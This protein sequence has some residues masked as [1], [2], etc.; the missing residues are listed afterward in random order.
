MEAPVVVKPKVAAVKKALSPKQPEKKCDCVWHKKPDG[1]SPKKHLDYLRRNKLKPSPCMPG[2]EKEKKDSPK[3][4]AISVEK[5][6]PIH[7]FHNAMVKLWHPRS[8]QTNRFWGNLVMVVREGKTPEWLITEHQLVPE[9]YFI[10]HNKKEINLMRVLKQGET[11]DVLRADSG[12]VKHLK[13]FECFYTKPIDKL[14]LSGYGAKKALLIGPAKTS[15]AMRYVGY[16]PPTA[17]PVDA[18]TDTSRKGNTLYH[19]ASTQNNSC[20]GILVDGSRIVGLHYGTSG[21]D[22]KKGMNNKAVVLQYQLNAK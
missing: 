1:I 2:F 12:W 19:S 13:G 9:A 21:A 18:V 16:D 6:L 7:H 22:N 10:D 4:E 17:E 14:I 3:K 5:P 11:L 8:V 20:G 15:G